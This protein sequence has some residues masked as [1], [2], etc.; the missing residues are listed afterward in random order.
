MPRNMKDGI[1]LAMRRFIH[2]PL[3]NSLSIRLLGENLPY[4]QTLRYGQG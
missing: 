2:S 1:R 3:Y 4:D